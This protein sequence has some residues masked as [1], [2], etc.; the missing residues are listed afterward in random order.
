M[1]S[2]D[3][4]KA[5][6]DL[7]ETVAHVAVQLSDTGRERDRLALCRRLETTHAVGSGDGKLWFDY[8]TGQ[9][10]MSL[11][12]AQRVLANIEQRA[13]ST[14]MPLTH[15]KKTA[16]GGVIVSDDRMGLFLDSEIAR[17]QQVEK[18][19]EKRAREKA[20]SARRRAEAAWDKSGTVA[21]KK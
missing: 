15:A 16:D 1:L 12:R 17:M 10:T 8:L 7:T 6:A 11:V 2:K 4:K 14:S 9:K 3:E 19:A 18:D 21:D 20:R 13:W 5:L